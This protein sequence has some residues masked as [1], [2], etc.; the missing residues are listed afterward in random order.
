MTR[1]S[2]VPEYEIYAIKYG[3][4]VGTRGTT[5]M[6][7]DPHDAPLPMDYYVWALKSP[8]RTFVVDVGFG[9]EEGERRGRTRA[10]ASRKQ[11]AAIDVDCRTG[12][13]VVL[14][15]EQ[16]ALGNL[17]RRAGAGDQVVG[18]LAGVRGLAFLALQR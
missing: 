5:F 1:S 12:D 6:G 9:R 8:E 18:G 13:E 17:V 14:D 11:P 10:P 7:G 3:E 4:R 2:N 16:D 15:D